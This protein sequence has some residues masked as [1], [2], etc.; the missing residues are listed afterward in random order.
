[1]LDEDLVPSALKL[2]KTHHLL[3][4]TVRHKVQVAFIFSCWLCNRIMQDWKL[5]QDIK[6]ARFIFTKS[7]VFWIQ[8]FPLSLSNTPL[9][10][11]LKAVAYAH[12]AEDGERRWSHGAKRSGF[13]LFVKDP[14]R[15]IGQDNVLYCVQGK[16]FFSWCWEVDRKYIYS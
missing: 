12:F 5:H 3:E 11:N 16:R 4:L 10:P 8:P 14:P 15:N 6:H 9:M 2:W 7:W 13:R 1:M